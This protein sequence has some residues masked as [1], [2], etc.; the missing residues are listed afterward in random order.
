MN[1]MLVMN[2]NRQ[3]L[4]VIGQKWKIINTKILTQSAACKN[5]FKSRQMPKC[6]ANA[7]ICGFTLSPVMN[8]DDELTLI[9][10]VIIEVRTSVCLSV[11]A[12]FYFSFNVLLFM[13]IH[14]IMF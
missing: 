11:Q 4:M 12:V 13:H 9:V 6:R 3:Q 10:C 14:N 2:G 8:I 1:A 5:H 7:K